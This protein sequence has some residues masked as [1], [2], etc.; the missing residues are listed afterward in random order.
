M[1]ADED[2]GDEIVSETET[3]IDRIAA[4]VDLLPALLERYRSGADYEAVTDRIQELESDCD[5]I[6]RR[7]SALV[8]NVSAEEIDFANSRIYLNSPGIVELYQKIDDIPNAVERIAEELVT[9]KP[10][11]AADC[12]RGFSD[13]TEHATT[14][15]TALATAVTGFVRVLRTPSESDSIVEEVETIREIES[16][17]DS[18]RNEIVETAFETASNARAIVYREFAHLFDTLVDAMEDVVDQIVLISS[19]EE[20][21]TTEADGQP[22]V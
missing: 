18:I 3:Y 16:A 14:A 20:W 7:I 17:C 6:N 1:A 5:R 22:T 11:T 19:T 8:T 9:I 21:I 10:S 15:M 12:F 13:M 2:F 4:C